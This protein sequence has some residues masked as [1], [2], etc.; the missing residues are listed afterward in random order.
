MKER[1]LYLGVEHEGD[2]QSEKRGTWGIVNTGSFGARVLITEEAHTRSSRG[3]VVEGR[4][5]KA[6]GARVFCLWWGAILDR[7]WGEINC[8]ARR[9]GE[10][11]GS[12][13]KKMRQA[14][15]PGGDG[16]NVGG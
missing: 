10:C 1:G 2:F 14:R 8:A 5:G 4:H 11:V 16:E 7:H 15:L 9:G 3:W 6:G 12:H 13:E